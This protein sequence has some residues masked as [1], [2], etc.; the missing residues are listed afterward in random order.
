LPTSSLCSIASLNAAAWMRPSCCRKNDKSMQPVSA[1]SSLSSLCSTASLHAA[2]WM[3]PSCCRLRMTRNNAN[4]TLATSPCQ[5]Q[6]QVWYAAWD[7]CCSSHC[8][9][10]CTQ[11]VACSM[12]HVSPVL[13]IHVPY[14]AQLRIKPFHLYIPD[15]NIQIL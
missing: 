11:R 9:Q 6:H 13:L 7:V 3:R 5:Q 15:S 10:K 4:Q 12:M 8:K 2:G 14:R 1:T